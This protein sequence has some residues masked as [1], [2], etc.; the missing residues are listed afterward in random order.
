MH[1]LLRR[2]GYDFVEKMLFERIPAGH[3]DLTSIG[4]PSGLA[5]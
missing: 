5:D 1:A 2:P 4:L 3:G